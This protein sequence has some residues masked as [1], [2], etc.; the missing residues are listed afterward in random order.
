[1]WDHFLARQCTIKSR[2]LNE[3]WQAICSVL[4]PKSDR[5]VLYPWELLTCS[6]KYTLHWYT[7]QPKHLIRYLKGINLILWLVN[8]IFA[9][10]FDN[11]VSC[12][13]SR[14]VE[15]LLTH[16]LKRDVFPWRLCG[17]I[18]HF[19]ERRWVIWFSQQFLLTV[20]FWLLCL[21]FEKPE[22]KERTERN[23][24]TSWGR[25]TTPHPCLVYFTHKLLQLQVWT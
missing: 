6:P 8:L 14:W 3:W 12:I 2:N 16:G 20:V 24:T 15:T 7:E 23:D 4:Q 1:M 21:F 5:L 10:C 22:K 13:S 9:L 11:D 25:C 17:K 19:A 18:H